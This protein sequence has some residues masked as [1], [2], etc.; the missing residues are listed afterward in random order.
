MFKSAFLKRLRFAPESR[1]ADLTER[2]LALLTHVFPKAD[3]TIDIT[4]T[5]PPGSAPTMTAA[6]MEAATELDHEELQVAIAKMT[7]ALEAIKGKR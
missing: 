5:G 6:P 2:H 4:F 3:A 7:K 1:G